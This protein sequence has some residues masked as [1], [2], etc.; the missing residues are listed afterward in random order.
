MMTPFLTAVANGSK[1]LAEWL[2]SNGADIN[3]G[4]CNLIM[5][6]KLLKSLKMETMPSLL[7]F[8]I[9]TSS[10][11]VSWSRKDLASTRWSSVHGK[12]LLYN[13]KRAKTEKKTQWMWTKVRIVHIRWLILIEVNLND[14]IPKQTPLSVFIQLINSLKDP[15]MLKLI[16]DSKPDLFLKGTAFYDSKCSIFRS[17]AAS[18]SKLW[19]CWWIPWRCCSWR[20]WRR[21]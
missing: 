13:Q 10:C 20:W 12:K 8:V 15:E 1:D 18:C 14:F 16:L 6:L 3:A 4:W 2:L 11:F 21:W 9:T 19:I 17:Q 7:L 5:E